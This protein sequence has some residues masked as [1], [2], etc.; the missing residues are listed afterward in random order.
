MSNAENL[1]D[2]IS[3]AEKSISDLTR[4]RRLIDKHK[5]AEE[6]HNLRGAYICGKQNILSKM[7]IEQGCEFGQIAIK[8]G[9]EFDLSVKFRDLDSEVSMLMIDPEGDL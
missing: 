4:A 1:N 7:M 2:L 3:L 9:F 8:G 5:L 6:M